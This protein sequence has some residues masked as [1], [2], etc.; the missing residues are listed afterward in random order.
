MALLILRRLFRNTLSRRVQYA[1]WGLVLIRLLIPA[2]LPAVDFSVLTAAQPVEQAV[3]GRIAERPVYVPVARAP[4]AEHPAAPDVSPERAEF[5]EAESVW[6]ARDEDTAVQ[7]RKLSVETLLT[8]VWK[9]G[10][11][12]MGGFFVLSNAAFYLR[13][14]KRRERFSPPEPF[15][16]A[17]LTSRKIYIVA[18]GV[19]P[20]PCLFGGAVY[21]TPAAV[22]SPD[23][24]RHVL[25]HEETHA[26]HLDPL[27]A[28]LRC[29][30][31]AVYWFD[32]LVWIAAACSKVDCELAC[33]EGALARLGERERIPYGETL[34]SLIPVR[35]GFGNPLTTATTM[36]AGKRQLRERVTRIA[37]MPR[38]LAA[39]VAAVLV[40]V[41]IA[42]ACTFTGAKKSSLKP[43]GDGDVRA[44]T[45]EELRWFNEVY[46]NDDGGDGGYPY[47]VPR[48]NIC[49]Q[50][51]NP[52]NLYEKPEDINLFELFYCYGTI[53]FSDEELRA[54]FD[55]DSEGPPPLGDK[56]TAEAIDLTLTRYTG[57]TLE[58]TNKVGLDGFTYLPDYDAYYLMHGDTNYPGNLSFLV[59][60]REGRT[61][62]LYQNS[63]FIDGWYRVT[64]EEQE[65]GGYYFVSNQACEKPAI[66]TPM[67]AGEPDTVIPLDGLEPYE[68]PAVALERCTALDLDGD[69]SDELITETEIFF[70]RDG[71]LYRAGLEDLVLNAC[72]AMDF[73]YFSEWDLYSKRLSIYG[74]GY[75]DVGRDIFR[76]LYFDGERL[77]LYRQETP[78]HDHLVDGAGQYVP[79]AVASAAKDLVEREFIV[80]QGD[81]T[82]RHTSYQNEGSP[83]ETYDDWRIKRFQHEGFE[84]VGD[85]ILEMWTFYYE[86]HTI[87]PENVV[88][89]GGRYLTEDN[90][91]SPGPPYNN[92]LFF[93]NEGGNL[94]FLWNAASK[95]AGLLQLPNGPMDLVQGFW[96]EFT[97]QD[98][99]LMELTTEDG[100]GGG[101]YSTSAG[102]WNAWSEYEDIT[103]DYRWETVETVTRAELS[104][105]NALTMKCGTKS[106]TLYQTPRLVEYRN[107]ETHLWFRAELAV[108][109]PNA[110]ELFEHI[111]H[112]YDEMELK[113][114]R[115]DV[116]I[117]DRGQGY[118]KVAREW[119]ERFEGLYLAVTPGSKYKC[120]YSGVQLEK[121]D[122]E[123]IYYSSQVEDRETF[124]FWYSVI[125]VPESDATMMWLVSWNAEEYEES[126]APEGAWQYHRMGELYLA[127]DG[128]R[129]YTGTG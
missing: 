8:A 13:L 35:K 49:N 111:R 89:A 75:L 86:L 126:G 32:P 26:R 107:G 20:S 17:G 68:A 41:G 10:A 40:L 124:R 93:R 101:A 125:A 29:V 80:A 94:T 56:L 23:A 78:Y 73:W 22:A 105:T 54:A 25:A 81:G 67:P 112:W 55:L 102:P 70:R 11:A 64:L 100:V 79:E 115:G 84:L 57:L 3:T 92:W 127:E 4:L 31:L 74:T 99:F 114:I 121:A 28:L 87:D 118:E 66:P 44:L 12:L 37:Q 110:F 47:R 62:A 60:T 65:D 2:S 96:D 52:L 39:A 128:W 120:T 116:A 9:I 104:E 34:L 46:F 95:A 122:G 36:T 24:L 6:V 83:Q 33:D 42:S 43:S 117:P 58:H 16:P 45:G 76:W 18:D 7:Y 91:V 103:S 129:D 85:E 51:A 123:L 82:W 50:F 59:G 61:V 14:R 72:P 113:A 27:W 119:A 108:N 53:N 21:L 77:L 98:E 5:P 48:Y 69:G 71:T 19:L 109:D 88:L 15:S 1:L 38:Q 90:W 30:C 97:A 63:D 106:L